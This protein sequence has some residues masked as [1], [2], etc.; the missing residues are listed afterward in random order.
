MRAILHEIK[1]FVN[2]Y[3]KDHEDVNHQN[4]N[5]NEAEIRKIMSKVLRRLT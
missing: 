4:I 3:R 2:I 5:K 1:I